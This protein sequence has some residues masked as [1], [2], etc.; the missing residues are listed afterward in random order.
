MI[1]HQLI[2]PLLGLGAVLSLLLFL[3]PIQKVSL[4]SC[5][6]FLKYDSVEE[7]PLPDFSDEQDIRRRKVRFFNYLMPMIQFENRRLADIRQRLVYIQDHIRN[8]RELNAQDLTWLAGVQVE[9]RLT[10]MKGTE[11]QFWDMIFL[12][13]D[14]LPAELVLVQAANESAWGTSRFAREGNN[15]FGQWCFSP[16]CGMVPE[17]RA[18]GDTHEVARFDSVAQ[19]VAAYMR[20]LNSG[21]AYD[22]L[23]GIRADLRSEGK[24]VTALELAPGLIRYSQRG[25]DYIRELSAMLRVNAPIFDE[26]R[27]P[28]PDKP[29][30]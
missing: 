15:F 14:Q 11:P 26:I 8:E 22:Q 30:A 10:E 19:S 17:G 12:R 13:V 7:I 25:E 2:I 5:P 28:G 16:G 18:P 23:R 29:E 24:P 20:N 9:F 21:F 27:S 4:E 1:R 6:I 3:V